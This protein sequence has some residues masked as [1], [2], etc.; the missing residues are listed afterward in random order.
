MNNYTDKLTQL[1]SKSKE[2]E[3]K[4]EHLISKRKSEIANSAYRHGLLT[5]NDSILSGAFSEIAEAMQLKSHKLKH[6]EQIGLKNHDFPKSKESINSTIE[7]NSNAISTNQP[8][9]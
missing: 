2:L 3:T 6:W 7:E 8:K 9:I 1:I 4:K 5:L